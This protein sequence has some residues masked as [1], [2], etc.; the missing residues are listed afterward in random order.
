ML[1][2]KIGTEVQTQLNIIKDVNAKKKRKKSSIYLASV[3]NDMMLGNNIK[4]KVI[5]L[6]FPFFEINIDRSIEC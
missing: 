6:I 2:N 4:V 5:K 3:P 1:S